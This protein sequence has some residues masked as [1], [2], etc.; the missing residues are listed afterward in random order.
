MKKRSLYRFLSL[1]CAAAVALVLIPVFA[2]AADLPDLSAFSD[3]EILTLLEQVNQAVV[4]R[5]IR[6]TA[7]L[8]Q[9]TYLAGR[10]LPAGSYVFTC[11][12]TGDDWGNVTVYS[13]GGSGDLLFWEVVTAPDQGEEPETFYLTLSEGDQLKSDVP[14]T[15]EVSGGVLFQ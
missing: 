11:L 4:E 3:E 13:D 9:G 7:K 5:G 10:E 2:G 15:L 1:L 8:P 6:K 14:F 12:A